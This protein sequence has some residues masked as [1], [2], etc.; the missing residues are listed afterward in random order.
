MST[1][2]NPHGGG[3]LKPLLLEGDALAAAET[4]EEGATK[5]RASSCESDDTNEWGING[6]QQ[7]SKSKIATS[8]ERASCLH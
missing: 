2:V 1:L 7:N 4:R 6:P 5:M 8:Q 3:R